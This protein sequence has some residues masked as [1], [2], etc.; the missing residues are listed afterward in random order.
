MLR[1][2]WVGSTESNN[3][4]PQKWG[5]DHQSLRSRAGGKLEVA[6]EL[7]FES[8]SLRQV[9]RTVE[10]AWPPVCWVRHC[11]GPAKV[12]AAGE[13]EESPALLRHA[14]MKCCHLVPLG[15]VVAPQCCHDAVK[16]PHPVHAAQARDILEDHEAG[17]QFAGDPHHMPEEALYTG[18]SRNSTMP[19]AT[20]I[21][22]TLRQAPSAARPCWLASATT[23]APRKMICSEVP[24][25][26]VTGV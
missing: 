21:H 14:E 20:E 9:S 6:A 12:L 2:A 11:R 15:L 4:T 19:L 23:R 16:E 1:S 5:E 26:S 17:A 8:G 24:P 25:Q 13:E 18:I 22:A 10:R 3:A 7:V